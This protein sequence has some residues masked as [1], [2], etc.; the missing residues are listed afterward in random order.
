M[1]KVLV[2]IFIA[3]AS[4]LAQDSAQT[5]AKK[6]SISS[7]VERWKLDTSKSD[8]GGNPVPK[9]ETLVITKNTPDMLAWRLNG[10]D[11]KGKAYTESWSGK[12]DGTIR[13]MSSS[14][15]KGDKASFKRNDD[16]S[17]TIHEESPKWSMDSQATLSD[18][19]NTMSE[20]AT[21]KGS[22]GKEAKMKSYGNA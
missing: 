13:P 9:S 10:V 2:C 16:G 14:M 3:A 12:P 6:P 5:T 22:D 7:G 4:L 21:M 17:Y 20:D 1:N 15:E 11:D 19:K 8:F 18:D